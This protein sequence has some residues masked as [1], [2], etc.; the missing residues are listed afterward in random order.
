MNINKERLAAFTDAIAAIAATIMVLE[1]AVPDGVKVTDLVTRWPTFLAYINSFFL[2]YLVWYNHHNLFEKAKIIDQRVF[3]MNGFWLFM[4]T[5]V[6]FATGWVGAHPNDT[7]PEFLYAVIILIWTISFQ[8]LDICIL[9]ANKDTK[10]DP[11]NALLPRGIIYILLTI[12][13]V[14][15]FFVPIATLMI[16][17]ILVIFMAIRMF[18]FRKAK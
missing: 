5:L 15:S 3:V 14:I 6:P 18:Y 16:Q 4:L 10:P 7:L 1:L 12:G 17:L 11:S 9:K 13:A 8:L 2:I